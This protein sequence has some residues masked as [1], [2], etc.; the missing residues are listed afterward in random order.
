MNLGRDITST[1]ISNLAEDNVVQSLENSRQ[2]LFTDEPI[3]FLDN[4]EIS[5]DL[6]L[7]SLTDIAAQRLLGNSNPKYKY[8]NVNN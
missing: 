3:S 4:T 1:G 2:I 7:R 6:I 8:I 5:D